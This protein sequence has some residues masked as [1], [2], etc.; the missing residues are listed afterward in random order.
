MCH[1]ECNWWAI[2]WACPQ[3]ATPPTPVTPQT[4]IEKSPLQF[5][6]QRSEMGEI[7]QQSALKIH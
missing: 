5:L 4:G 2:D 6:A 1:W 7:C 3:P